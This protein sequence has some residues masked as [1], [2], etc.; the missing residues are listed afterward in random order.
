MKTDSSA[1]LDAQRQAYHSGNAKPASQTG[2]LLEDRL[3]D[4]MR[5]LGLDFAVSSRLDIRHKTDFLIVH[6]QGAP[7]IHPVAFQVTLRWD[8]FLK[9]QA[10]WNDTRTIRV[11]DVLARKLYLQ[12]Q[13]TVC[14]KNVARAVRDFVLA[15]ESRGRKKRTVFAE[16]DKDGMRE[17]DV[18]VRL[19]HLRRLTDPRTTIQVRVT[20]TVTEV[21]S[22]GIRLQSESGKYAWAFL[23]QITDPLLLQRVSRHQKNLGSALGLFVSFIPSLVANTGGDPRATS[24][25]IVQ[26]R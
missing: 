22:N 16:M 6:C 24:V 19:K 10:F 9:L 2:L 11:Q 8:D 3:A 23:S 5:E 14:P 15:K 25:I 7:P 1:F 21:Q 20:G 26:E 17:F 12:V 13:T 18:A 4:A